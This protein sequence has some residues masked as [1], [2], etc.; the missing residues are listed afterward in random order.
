M[1][2]ALGESL[3]YACCALRDLLAHN[4]HATVAVVLL[5]GLNGVTVRIDNHA[6]LGNA[7]VEESLGYLLGACLG[8]T[9]VDAFCIVGSC[10]RLFYSTE[11]LV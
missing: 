3:L 1:L 5:E 11:D 8:I 4:N 2:T 9:N 7:L 10:E 6:L